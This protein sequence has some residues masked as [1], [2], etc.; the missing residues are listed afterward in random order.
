MQPIPIHVASA[1]NGQLVAEF[2][3]PQGAVTAMKVRRG[4]CRES[5]VIAEYF[6]LA[7]CFDTVVNLD[8][9]TYHFDIEI[10]IDGLTH[11]STRGRLIV[12]G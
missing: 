3:A 10:T 11:T 12:E 1:R 8:A 6:A 4:M 7:G 2:P 9:G 5:A